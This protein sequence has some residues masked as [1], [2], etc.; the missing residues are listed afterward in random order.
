MSMTTSTAVACRFRPTAGRQ[1]PRAIG[2]IILAL[3]LLVGNHLLG[4]SEI[5]WNQP[6][7]PVQPTNVFYGWNQQSMYNQP[8][9]A[10]DDWVCA[11]TNPVTKIRWW[12]SFPN[13]QGTTPA[14]TPAVVLDQVLE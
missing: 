9:V 2:T 11:T 4:R 12:G 5:K 1:A 8:P 6:P 7:D 3:S 14:T 13:W 10:A